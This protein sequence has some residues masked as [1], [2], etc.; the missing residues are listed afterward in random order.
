MQWGLV[1]VLGL[2]AQAC[3][4]WLMHGALQFNIN[5]S[6]ALRVANTAGD[7]RGSGQGECARPPR[8]AGSVPCPPRA[9]RCESE[10]SEATQV[11]FHFIASSV[12][13]P[14]GVLMLV[15]VPAGTYF[16]AL[17]W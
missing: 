8:C 5:D 13:M 9:A 11:A 4:Q 3:G 15:Q 7:R 1:I 6:I 10:G 2:E 16:Q 17:P 14:L 12:P